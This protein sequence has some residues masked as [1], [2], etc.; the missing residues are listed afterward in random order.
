MI[1]K[2]VVKDLDELFE[3]EQEC[4]PKEQAASYE[5]LKGRLLVYPDNFFL[6]KDGDRIV[7]FINGP[8]SNA[9]DLCDDM[10]VDPFLHDESGTWQFLL[11]VDTRTAYRNHGCASRLM[12]ECINE[13]RRQGRSGIVLTCLEN[14]IP[15]YERFGFA[16]EGISESVHG[17]E[18]WYQMRLILRHP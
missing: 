15:F 12:H 3:I 1:C 6:L 16:N 10:Y 14:M 7:S 4:F 17:D 9:K 2:A 13:C 8:C 5:A 18:L 11:G